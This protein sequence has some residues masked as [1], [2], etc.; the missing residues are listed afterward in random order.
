MHS[1]KRTMRK[2]AIFL[3]TVFLLSE[4]ICAPYFYGEVYYYQDGYVRESMAGQLDLLVCGASQ[5]LRGISPAVLDEEL[6][7]N[8]Y[9]LASPLMT[10]KQRYLFLK[11]ELER[12]PVETVVVEICYDSLARDRKDVGPEGDFYVLGR[13]TNPW[14]RIRFL[15]DNVRFSE[16]FEFYANTLVRGVHSAKVMLSGGGRRG[17]GICRQ[18]KGYRPLEAKPMEISPEYLAGGANTEPAEENLYYFEKILA[19]CVEKKVPAVLISTPLPQALVCNLDGLETVRQQHAAIAEKYGI[20]FLDFSLLK[21]RGELFQDDRDFYDKAHLS[22]AGA[23][24][25]TRVLARNLQNPEDCPLYDS[26]PQMLREE[27]GISR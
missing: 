11:K 22:A 25:F 10:M 7:C 18:D 5:S 21:G 12:N 6:G 14:D 13:F 17:T 9:S 15:A 27:Y 23:E 8:S 24:R 3:L 19:L 4:A 20:P 26:Y 1:F 16:I 2:I